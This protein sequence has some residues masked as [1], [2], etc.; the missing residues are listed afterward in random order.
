MVFYKMQIKAHNNTTHHILKNEAYLILPKFPKGGKSKRGIFSAIISGF[1]GLEFEGISRF[2]H[3]RRH[4]ALHKADKTMSIQTNIPRNKLMHLENN[5]VMYGVHNAETLIK[6]VHALHS[7][8]TLYK[9]LFAGKTSAA[10]EFYT[11]MHGERGI[12]HY[13]IN[14]MLYLRTIKDKYIEIYN[15]FISQLHVYAKAVRILAKGYLPISFITP[16]KLQ[17]ILNSVKETLTKTNPDYNIVIKRLHLYYNMKLVTFGTDRNR[18]LIIQFPIFV[19]PYTQ[20]Q[21][22]LYQ[23]ETV[24]VPIVDKHTKVYSYTQLQIKKPYLALNTETYINIRQQG[25]ATCKR[26]G[27]EFFCE[28][29]FI[30]R[31][32]SIHSSKSAIFFYLDK[33]LIKCNC[34]FTFYYN[35]TDITLTVLDK[36]NEI[37]LGNW[38]SDKHIICTIN[39]GIPIEILSHP[40]IL[41]NRSLLCNWYGSGK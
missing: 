9:N 30:V 8:Q 12:Q 24:P 5:L 19:Q 31:Y 6:T 27:Y 28:E 1:V 10:Y 40:Y 29:L 33:D 20:Q 17:E 41:V 26:I 11:Q 35:K 2:L 39:N 14:S 4:K 25:L 34:D 18:N 13:A 15:E 22:T 23:L 36:G 3:K 7:R 21:L 37:I 32:K 16:L 38:P